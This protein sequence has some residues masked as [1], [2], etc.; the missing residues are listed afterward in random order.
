MAKTHQRATTFVGLTCEETLAFNNE[1]LTPDHLS[2]ISH[3]C[4]PAGN[5]GDRKPPPPRLASEP[6]PLSGPGLP[7]PPLLLA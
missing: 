2:E 4:P 6:R 5:H 7:P 3:L 1:M